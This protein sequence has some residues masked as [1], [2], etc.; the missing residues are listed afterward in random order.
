MTV[1]VGAD[2]EVVSVQVGVDGNE[3]LRPAH[4]PV[5]GVVDVLIVILAEG[6]E[7]L[8]GRPENEDAEAGQ[9]VG[10]EE[11]DE[12]AAR[13][14]EEK[15]HDHGAENAVEEHAVLIGVLDAE[16]GEDRHH[17]EE[18]VDGE[19]FLKQIAGNEE[20]HLRG[21]FIPAD[22][23]GEGEGEGNPDGRPDGGIAGGDGLVVVM[24]P[25]VYPHADDD[26][27]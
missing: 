2:E 10:S 1:G 14:H 17:D 23:A 25:K 4:G 12:G 26:H 22:V 5:L 9:G 11:L 3:L 8:P 15:T 24:G 13:G 6:L 21:A 19:G 16:G 20:L 7:H 18:V 27:Q